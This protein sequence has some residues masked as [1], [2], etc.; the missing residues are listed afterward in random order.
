MVARTI[1]VLVVVNVAGW[2]VPVGVKLQTGTTSS[3]ELLRESVL[4]PLICMSLSSGTRKWL[5]ILASVSFG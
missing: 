4:S 5:A 1:G 2:L 3:M